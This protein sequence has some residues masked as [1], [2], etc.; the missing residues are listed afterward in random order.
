[1][2]LERGPPNPP[3]FLQGRLTALPPLTKSPSTGQ[4]LPALSSQLPSSGPRLSPAGPQHGCGGSGL[5]PL[6]GPPKCQT[7]SGQGP[8]AQVLPAAHGSPQAGEWGRRLN[9]AHPIH[10]HLGATGRPPG[11]G[12]TPLMGVSQGGQSLEQ[13]LEAPRRRTPKRRGLQEQGAWG[14]V[15]LSPQTWPL[16]L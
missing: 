9:P 15:S 7:V 13:R 14:R 6:S 1:M 10:P 5:S 11:L 8:P 3:S 16:W 4:Y 12:L 2:V